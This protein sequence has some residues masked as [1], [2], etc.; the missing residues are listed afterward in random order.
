MNYL[1]TSK[2]LSES[3]NATEIDFQMLVSELSAFSEGLQTLIEEKI[4]LELR[5]EGSVD[6]LAELCLKLNKLSIFE[7]CFRFITLEEP[8]NQLLNESFNTLSH[9]LVDFPSF[10]DKLFFFVQGLFQKWNPLIDQLYN[11][12]RHK[13]AVRAI[14]GPTLLWIQDSLSS[15]FVPSKLP[16]FKTNFTAALAFVSRIEESFFD[17]TDEV[18]YFRA[19]SA[20]SSFMKKWSLHQYFQMQLRQTINPIEAVL[21]KSLDI[22]NEPKI[23]EQTVNCLNALKQLWGPN[24]LLTPLIPKVLK[25]S[26]QLFRRF[27]LF[28]REDASAFSNPS[29][30]SLCCLQKRFNLLQFSRLYRETVL[31]AMRSALD[32]L[33]KGLSQKINDT[34]SHEIEVTLKGI[35]EA[36]LPGIE[37]IY[38]RLLIAA[39]TMQYLEH[40]S[41]K[42]LLLLLSTS[43]FDY[44]APQEALSASLQRILI[45]VN[46]AV[47]KLHDQLGTQSLAFFIEKMDEL[48]T[49][50]AQLGRVDLA[51][52][53]F[54]IE[55]KQT[56]QK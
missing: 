20:W 10:L 3:Q 27:L 24:Y 23:L 45:K 31:P 41:F 5:N 19:H 8:L 18:S 47:F 12:D 36:I 16:E 55:I 26:M 4:I 32:S 49:E 54:W 39:P 34:F 56:I 46:R 30:F 21:S 29:V 22:V 38:E 48:E 50:A 35:E 11:E 53:E 17:F 6:L 42:A 52:E 13:F 43:K 1:W 9:S 7:S 14:L 28:C 2:F 44:A 51:S 25:T 33:E 40:L 15:V 37:Q